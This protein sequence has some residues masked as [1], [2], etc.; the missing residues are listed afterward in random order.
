MFLFI[1]D[2]SDVLESFILILRLLPVLEYLVPDI[3]RAVGPVGQIS[4]AA[5]TDGASRGVQQP[6]AAYVFATV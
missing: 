5:A 4:A 3:A 2:R 6:R 1:I